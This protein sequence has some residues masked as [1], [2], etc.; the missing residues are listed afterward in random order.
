MNTLIGNLENLFA[1]QSVFSLVNQMMA[2]DGDHGLR[3][4]SRIVSVL[5]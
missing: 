3:Q 2:N 4:V 5:L 1:G